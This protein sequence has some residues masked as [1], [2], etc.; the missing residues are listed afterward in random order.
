ISFDELVDGLKTMIMS[1]INAELK[2][3]EQ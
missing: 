2:K 1:Y 3:A